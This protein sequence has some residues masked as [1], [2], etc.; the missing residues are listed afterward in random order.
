MC[1]NSL[2]RIDVNQRALPAF[3][4]LCERTPLQIHQHRNLEVELLLAEALFRHIIACIVCILDGKEWKS[5]VMGGV[6]DYLQ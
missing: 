4:S 1:T 5:F 2:S 3:A 6:E